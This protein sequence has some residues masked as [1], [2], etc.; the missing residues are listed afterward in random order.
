VRQEF[1]K[2]NTYLTASEIQKLFQGVSVDYL[3]LPAKVSQQTLRV[4]DSNW[5][6]YFKSIKD[7]SKNKDKYLGKPKLPKYL[8]KN[9]GRFISVY[10]AQAISKKYLKQGIINL[11][12]TN[13]KIKLQHTDNAI[14]QARIVPKNRLYV[15]EIIYEQEIQDLQL[16]KNAVIGIDI[17]LNNLCAVG[18]NNKE[19][20]PF[21]IN[22]KPL[23]SINHYYNKKKAELQSCLTDT[24]TSSAIINLSNKRNNKVKNYLH[25]TSKYIVDYCLTND[26]GKIIIGHNKGWKQ[27]INIGKRNNQNFVSI[28]Y[29]ILIDQITYKSELV[30][31]EVVVVEESYTS[32]CSFL[33]KEKPTKQKI[34]IGKRVKRGLF[35]SSTG[36]LINADIN[37]AY[38]IIR[39]VISNFFPKKDEIKG[40]AVSPKLVTA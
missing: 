11:S 30:G 26:I 27:K 1:F 38:N 3:A 34:Y 28:P 25:A 23:K 40:F 39:K 15:I 33:D 6:S 21:L 4:L 29:N 5:K 22:G 37:A 24:K 18:S 2:S 8:H 12:G 36:I 19:L 16:N 32:K 7:W 31:I 35:K 17:G 14:K 20:L 9:K 10:D 13:I